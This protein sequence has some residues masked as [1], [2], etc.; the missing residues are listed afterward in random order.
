MVLGD[1]PNAAADAVDK[2]SD[3]EYFPAVV[4]TPFTIALA[5]LD[6]EIGAGAYDGAYY[7]NGAEKIEYYYVTLDENFAGVS[8]SF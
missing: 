2:R 8:A 3:K 1:K 6:N 4:G 5:T 7:R